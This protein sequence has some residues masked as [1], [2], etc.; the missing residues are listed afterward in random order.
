MTVK[1]NEEEPV[2]SGFGAIRLFGL[3]TCMNLMSRH[4][5]GHLILLIRAA[6]SAL[7]IQ[8]VCQWMFN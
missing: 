2:S 8:D 1:T 6:P 3:L 7:L 5:D 4:G